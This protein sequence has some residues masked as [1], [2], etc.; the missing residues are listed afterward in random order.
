M[1]P[2]NKKTN[3]AIILLILSVVAGMVFLTPLL[4]F[5]FYDQ[6]RESLGMSDV[7]IGT[8]G[9]VYGAFNVITYPLSGI[10]AEKFST[11][12]ML[13]VSAIG[14]A[15]VTL[16]YATLPGYIALLI[17][18]AVYGV[19]SVG[20]FWS[21]YLKA[22]RELGSNEEQ[23][24][25]Y[26][27][28]EALRGVAQTIVSSLCLLALANIASAS[29]GF[30]VL[31]FINAAIFVLLAIAVFIF[32]PETKVEKKTLETSTTAE[33]KKTAR[34]NIVLKTLM[35]SSTWICIF[36]IACGYCLWHTTNG[37]IGTYCTRV[38]HLSN[39]M[40]STISIIRSYIIVFVAGISGGIIM[41]KFKTKGQ[42]MMLAYAGIAI[43]AAAIIFTGKLGFICVIVT[44]I[45]SYLTNVVK[46]T[47]WS[48]LGD[49][50][51]P[52][53]ST[54]MASGIISFIGNTPEI[55]APLIVS[56]FI[57]YGEKIGNVE[58][59]F[60]MMLVWCVVW[61]VLGIG[62]GMILKKRKEKLVSQE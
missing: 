2:A 31:L 32:V 48:I 9:A 8:I 42:G 62:A 15:V 49:A 22:V 46:A 61:G 36:V 25:L 39:S 4:R 29:T 57:T 16:W 54:G 10:L 27:T 34:D 24:R 53:E 40:S 58:L 41:D 6:M 13:L 43:S 60:N 52:L 5:S 21:P 12:K 14:M 1:N 51:V 3:R 35:N 17:I 50:G 45:L 37:Y 19:F 38:L 47:Y 55:F 7:Q 44:L 30:R 23:G 33:K 11:K 59:G 18:H 56:R 20:T 26:G 28:S